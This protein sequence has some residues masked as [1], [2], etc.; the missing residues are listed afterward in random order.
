[1]RF[2]IWS[3]FRPASL[4]MER[5]RYLGKFLLIG[6]VMLAPLA[7][8][9]KAYLD[10]QGAQIGFSAKERVGVTYITPLSRVLVLTAEMRAQAIDAAA[11][12]PGAQAR[13]A[14]LRESLAPAVRQMNAVDG[15]V[16]GTLATTKEWQSLRQ[17]LGKL[18]AGTGSQPAAVLATYNAA[19]AAVQHLIVTA[20]NN[21]NLILDP[22][23]D[24]FYLM[25]SMVNRI[26]AL[27]DQAGAATGLE[28]AAAG[29]GSTSKS[30]V[31]FAVEKG[32][33]ASTLDLNKAN[34]QT[35]FANT[36]DAS[37]KRVIAPHLAASNRAAG[38]VVAQL[39]R[40]GDGRVDASDAST[41]GAQ[42]VSAAAALQSAVAPR[43]DALLATRIGRL[44]SARSR[45]EVVAVL[46]LL[47]ALYLFVGFY[48]STVDALGRITGAARRVALGQI[49]M[50]IETSARDE[51]GDVLREFDAVIP[52]LQDTASA[53]RAIASGDVSVE[54]AP[55]GE[56]DVLGAA[57]L[58]M[59][60]NLRMMA[61]AADRIAAGDLSHTVD[62]ASDRDRFGIAFAGMHEYLTE[63]AAA[64]TA[65]SEG[66]TSRAVNVRSQDDV[67]GAA[68][69]EMQAYLAD[70]V[71]AAER[72][73]S[74]DLTEA[75]EPRSHR[76]A[77]GDA[78][79]RMTRDVAGV[80]TDVRSATERLSAKS[81]EM[82]SASG[83]AGRAVQEIAQSMGQVAQGAEEQVRM[84]AD[85]S[86]AAGETAEVA[87][88]A[89]AVADQGIGAAEDA[90]GAIRGLSDSAA[91]LAETMDVLARRSDQIGGIVETISTIA[92]QTNLLALNAAVEAARAGDQG[93]GFAVVAD[94]VRK[95]A[96]DSKEAAERIAELIGEI[97]SDTGRASSAVLESADRTRD[98]VDRVER[99]RAAF[100]GISNAVSDITDRAQAINT[101]TDHIAAVAEQ[102][103][104]A[105]EQ[106]SAASQ[107]TTARTEELAS[108]S[109]DVRDT[110]QEL[111]ALVRRFRLPED[112]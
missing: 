17:R 97:Q 54:V 79:A 35:A 90:T 77:L 27:L 33:I 50:R 105:V 32:G 2:S 21:S 64:A 95:L 38:A 22:D 76:D 10:Q 106:V 96:E 61:Q 29:D 26:P 47:I 93:R 69:A 66:D 88:Q 91:G 36:K 1:M 52:Y 58:D 34:M 109:R 98:G 51:V 56:G 110:A 62:P 40:A 14:T 23:L 7:Y 4:L 49:D 101:A 48:R 102:S 31:E 41:A 75:V 28:I 65:I 6:L 71:A 55:R 94:E 72:I 20:G 73:A 84:I 82:S 111:H 3:V 99:A 83:E 46:A 16:G 45:V 59:V 12:T 18:P 107:E 70:M 8:V 44:E 104:A 15:D 11:G 86:R 57:L 74:G 24:S 89:N 25:D 67:L 53:A 9:G 78:F 60:T 100:D 5:L 42:A 87:L 63:M 43:L 30:A 80:L 108:A 19:T 112:R 37:V 39:G 85:A 103:S 13:L 92:A 81:E 68:F